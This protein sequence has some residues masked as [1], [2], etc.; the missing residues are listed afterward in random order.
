MKQLRSLMI[1]SGLVAISACSTGS[2]DISV[3][4]SPVT[5]E[6]AMNDAVKLAIPMGYDETTEAGPIVFNEDIPT[7]GTASYTGVGLVSV[8]DGEPDNFGDIIFFGS[9]TIEADFA[10]GGNI[11]GEMTDFHFADISDGVPDD[12]YV[13]PAVDGSLTINNSEFYDMVSDSGAESDRYIAELADVP[14]FTADVTGTLTIPSDVVMADTDLAIDIDTQLFA[15]FTATGIFGQ[16]L[17]G[18]EDSN[19][20]TERDSSVTIIAVED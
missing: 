7:S 13:M 5:Y 10:D 6:S 16:G 4:S 18:A 2:D 12:D 11:T 3:T 20:N 8:H 17:G 15:G 1:L 14:G 19:G 9:T